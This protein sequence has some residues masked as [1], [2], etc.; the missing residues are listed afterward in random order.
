[1]KTESSF[2]S[3]VL[4]HLRKLRPDYVVTKVSDRYTA[5]VPDAFFCRQGETVWLEMK[6]ATSKAPNVNTLL[7]AA[8]TRTLTTMHRLG[9]PYY[10][11]VRTPERW[12]VYDVTG[13]VMDLTPS[14]KETAEWLC[15]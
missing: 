1:M 8:Q 7:T 3:E 2:T 6:R 13:F 4:G 5:G 14:S 15:L 10:V 9:V 12:K 11:L